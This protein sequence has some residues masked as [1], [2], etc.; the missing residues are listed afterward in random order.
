MDPLTRACRALAPVLLPLL[1]LTLPALAGCA[2][3]GAGVARAGNGG[4]TLRIGAIPDQDQSRL[5]RLYGEVADYLAGRLG[6]AVVYRPV[7]DYAAA[8]TAFRTGDL[9]A[10]WFG[11]FTGAQAREQVPD[12][13]PLAQ[14]DIDAHFRSVFVAH[15]GSGLAPVHDVAGLRELAGRRFTFGSETSTSGRLMPQWYLARAGVGLDDFADRPGFSGSHDAT[16][17]EVEA[18]S[19]EAGAVNEQVWRASLADGT[20]DRA[21]VRA[22]FTTPPYPDYH[23]LAR[24]D[25]DARF[26][27]GFTRRL[28]RAFL[29]L[30][31]SQA[32]S[33]EILTLFGAR[34]FVR[35]TPGE[36]ALTRRAV[37][38][39]GLG[40]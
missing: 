37:H 9:D 4:A 17:R 32:R 28:Q 22:I 1:L 3:G 21:K 30:D 27:A 5:V 19:F 23:W 34:R 25:L 10:V 15:A 13:V 18:G 11:G 39:L 7:T 35:T 36:Y 8:V 24:P 20:V 12:A 14:R 2:G 16:I 31:R 40:G 29:S 33:R 26:G 38:Q 6:V